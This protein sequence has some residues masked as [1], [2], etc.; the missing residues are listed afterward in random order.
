MEDGETM[1]KLTDAEI[2]KALED[3][4]NR[5][6][7]ED[8]LIVPK[9]GIKNLCIGL[10]QAIDLINRQKEEKEHLEYVLMAVMHSVDKW[11]EGDELKQDEANRACTMREKP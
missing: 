5:I 9:E 11:L 10:E 7:N 2:K 3:T 6:K 1:E 4:I 8:S